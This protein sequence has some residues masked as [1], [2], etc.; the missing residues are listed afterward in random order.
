MARSEPTVSRRD[1]KAIISSTISTRTP[2]MGVIWRRFSK[3]LTL[4]NI[5]VMLALCNI[6]NM[7]RLASHMLAAS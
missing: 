6:C 4:F 7:I 3:M 1:F 5:I 2:Q